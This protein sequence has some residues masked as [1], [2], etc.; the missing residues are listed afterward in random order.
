M[1]KA[2]R[3]PN[4][5]VTQTFN[6]G[7]VRICTAEDGAAPGMMPK[8]KLRPIVKLNYEEQRLGISRYYQGRQNQIRI[9]RVIRVPQSCPITTQMIAVTEDCHPYRIDLVQTADV[10]PPSLDLTLTAVEQDMEVDT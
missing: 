5:A 9:E 1:W 3:R 8:P 7:V 6:S 2:P 4:K 10:Y